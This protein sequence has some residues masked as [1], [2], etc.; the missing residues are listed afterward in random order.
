MV[1]VLQWLLS[2]RLRL[3][4]YAAGP[5]CRRTPG[6]QPS[7]KPIPSNCTRKALLQVSEP[8]RIPLPPLALQPFFPQCSDS[9]VYL[10]QLPFCL[11]SFRPSCSDGLQILSSNAVLLRTASGPAAP[12]QI[13]VA[14]GRCGS[15]RI[16]SASQPTAYQLRLNLCRCSWFCVHGSVFLAAAGL[17]CVRPRPNLDDK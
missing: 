9:R 6:S 2:R 15:R 13:A 16:T 4:R 1:G 17:R 11:Q 3:R 5:G 10:C 14:A 12:H 7:P 8:W